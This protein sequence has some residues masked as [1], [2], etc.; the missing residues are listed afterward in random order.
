MDVIH[1]RNHGAL[2]YPL[3]Q[4][5]PPLDTTAMH[6]PFAVWFPFRTI[7]ARRHTIDPHLALRKSW[8]AAN[9]SAM[10]LKVA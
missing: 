5:L 2:R 10:S 4:A 8:S 1:L 3:G 7:S 9:A 6:A